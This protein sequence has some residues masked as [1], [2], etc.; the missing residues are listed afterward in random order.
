[1]YNS[2][3]GKYIHIKSLI[4]N[5]N[6]KSKIIC[7]FIFLLS[8][9]ST[10]YI[11]LFILTILTLGLMLISRVP[12]KLYFNSIY[13]LKIF[14]LFVI[15][16]TIV[17]R[18]S[19]AFMMI[20]LLKLIIGILYT[21]ILTF[22]TSKSEITS[23]LE[24]VLEPLE[25]INIPVKRMALMLTLALRFIPSIFEQTEKIRKSQ[26][27]RG[28]DF[29]YANLKGKIVAITS[30]IVPMFILTSKKSER[31]ADAMEV[32]LYGYN[33]NRTNYRFSKW[34][35]IDDAMIIIHLGILIYAIIRMWL[36]W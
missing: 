31:I 22:T 19:I 36:L 7:L 10:D 32:R 26:A 5:M 24:K 34:T 30:M 2:M 1:M 25:K 8:L 23:G 20:T 21:M 13:G 33:S 35:N 4:H 28:I 18:G 12:L 14:I 27:S 11:V 29:K 6:S 3:I 16:I 17:F 15:I 9:F